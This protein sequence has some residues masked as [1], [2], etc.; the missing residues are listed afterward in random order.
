MDRQVATKIIVAI[1]F[2]NM[3]CAAFARDWEASVRKLCDAPIS[4][5]SPCAR[6]CQR[7]T[8][9]HKFDDM[10][11]ETQEICQFALALDAVRRSYSAPCNT[12]ICLYNLKPT[13]VTKRGR[14][15][16][17][18]YLGDGYRASLAY[19]F[20]EAGLEIDAAITDRAGGVSKFRRAC[21]GDGYCG[22]WKYRSGPIRKASIWIPYF[23]NPEKSI[24]IS[25]PK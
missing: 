23:N 8:A 20:G 1:A 7:A 24:A 9:Y 14:R 5:M 2:L 4:K 17:D 16:V 3:N 6:I 18:H 10:S 19:S 13:Q 22:R 11:V 25:V 21:S 15:E 12:K